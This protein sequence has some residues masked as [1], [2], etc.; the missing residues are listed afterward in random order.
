MTPLPSAKY[1]AF[2]LV[3][4]LLYSCSTLYTL[5]LN[6]FY[7]VSTPVCCAMC[8]ATWAEEGPFAPYNIN[9]RGPR[10]IPYEFTK[11]ATWTIIDGTEG[12]YTRL[13]LK[14]EVEAGRYYPV[15]FNFPHHCW[16]EVHFR[17]D[18]E[19]GQYWQAFR[20][21]A[22]DLGLDITEA[23][24]E[25][26]HTLLVPHEAASEGT[27]S[28]RS[29][30]PSSLASHPEVIEVWESPVPP[31]SRDREIAQLAEFLHIT[32]H[33]QM[34]QMMPVLSQVGVINPVTG[35]MTTEDD[36]AMYRANLSD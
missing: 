30:T 13:L 29:N 1:I 16:V 3:Y 35:H 7:K 27:T 17:E 2:C 36:V 4:C 8:C 28:T 11:T 21:T 5:S 25:L 34:S 19:F 26:H 24:V 9:N 6:T 31:P 12:Y 20:T 10:N 33:H 22:T 18:E 32:D 14:P 23:E 15:E